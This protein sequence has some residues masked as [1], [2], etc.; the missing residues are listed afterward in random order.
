MN[1]P[2]TP[3]TRYTSDACFRPSFPAETVLL[4]GIADLR[5]T[6]IANHLLRKIRSCLRQT[7]F[8]ASVIPGLAGEAQKLEPLAERTWDQSR[9]PVRRIQGRALLV[10]NDR[11]SKLLNTQS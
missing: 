3:Y 7:K 8:L 9:F 6:E 11:Q 1:S 4:A 2:Y 10:E 5:P